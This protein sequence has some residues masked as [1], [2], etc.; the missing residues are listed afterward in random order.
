MRIRDYDEQLGLFHELDKLEE[1]SLA[2]NE[3]YELIPEIESCTSLIELDLS[4]NDLTTIPEEVFNLP[5]LKKL[6][7]TD[8]P[9]SKEIKTYLKI[10][11]ADKNDGCFDLR[12]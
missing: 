9:I 10:R 4:D 7:L 8:N 2:S 3:I 5:K 12:F 11:F 1:L 6:I